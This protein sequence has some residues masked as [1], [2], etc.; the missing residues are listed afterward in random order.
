[1]RRPVSLLLCPSLLH[2]QRLLLCP[3]LPHPQRLL[4]LCLLLSDRLRPLLMACWPPLA[5]PLTHHW[6]PA[7]SPAST[8]WLPAGP[9]TPTCQSAAPLPAVA[10]PCPAAASPAS[11]PWI[12]SPFAFLLASPGAPS[13][14][15]L[16]SST[17]PSICLLAPY[18]VLSCSCL[19]FVEGP[20]GFGLK[21]TFCS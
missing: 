6:S 21:V 13:Y 15:H 19:A 16:A 14:F 9:P 10:T 12:R 20:T 7:G 18:E 1:M 4:L 5:P 11:S 8:R 17:C 2:P 3:S